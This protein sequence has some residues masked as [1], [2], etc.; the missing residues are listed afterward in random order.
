MREEYMIFKNMICIAVLLFFNSSTSISGMWWGYRAL[1][2]EEEEYNKSGGRMDWWV[3]QSE[4]AHLRNTLL[5]QEK[6]KEKIREREY[7]EQIE[8]QNHFKRLQAAAKEGGSYFSLVPPEILNMA[9]Q[10]YLLQK[11]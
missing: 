2:I 10:Y 11:K 8:R 9:G 1:E 4:C 5:T 6:S 3:P 7:Q